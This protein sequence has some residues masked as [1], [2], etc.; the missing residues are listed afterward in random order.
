MTSRMS[1][2]GTRRAGVPS[3]VAASNRRTTGFRDF[4][5]VGQVAWPLSIAGLLLVAAAPPATAQEAPPSGVGQAPAEADGQGADG[6]GAAGLPGLP[7]EPLPSA[8][9]QPVEALPVGAMPVEAPPADVADE[10]VAPV[11]AEHGA[12]EHGAGEHGAAE[13]GAAEHGAAEHGAAEHGAAEHAAEHEGHGAGAHHEE[14]HGFNVM[15]FVATVVNFLIWLAIVIVLLRKPLTTHLQNRRLAILEGL[16][17]S[18]R[19]KEAAEQK[20]AEYTERLA[21]L[22]KELETLRKEMIQAGEVERDRI[23]AEA[24]ARTARMRRDAQFVIEQQMKQ[25]RADLTREAIE[26]AVSAAEQLLRQQ[27]AVADQQRLADAYLGNIE[28]S[29][30]SE[31]VGAA[32]SA[33]KRSEVRA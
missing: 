20:H 32:D 14:A 15:D 7:A 10:Q 9:L 27:T 1:C 28:A 12:G 29:I 19:L 22:D 11:A 3:G 13:H 25:L 8:G 6:Q 23:V 21:N 33:A 5:A 24:E 16:E 26:S 31:S 4:V 30:K 17:Q 18:A 2:N